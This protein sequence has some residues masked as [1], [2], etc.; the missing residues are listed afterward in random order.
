VIYDVITIGGGLGGAALAR[1]MALHGALVLVIEREVQFRDRVRGEALHPWGFAE[2]RALGIEPLLRA[3]GGREVRWWRSRS[4]GDERLT[5]RDLPAT[6]PHGT[7]EL[8]VD[9]AAMQELLLTSAAEAGACVRRGTVVVSLVPGDPPTVTVRDATGRQETLRA[10]L[11]VAADGRASRARGWAGFASRHDP[12]RLVIA[13]ALLAGMHL[14]TDGV[15]IAR[16]PARAV[17]LVLPAG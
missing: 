1:A 15:Q 4:R 14:P 10:R 9:H 6:T 7:G 2:A 5:A 17:G 3:A 16:D 8:T 12:K 11:V 13:G